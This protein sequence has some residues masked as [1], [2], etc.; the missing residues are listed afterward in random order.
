[1]LSAANSTRSRCASS[2]PPSMAVTI[3]PATATVTGAEAEQIGGRP[4]AGRRLR[5]RPKPWRAAKATFDRGDD[6]AG[7]A[8][9][10]G[11]ERQALLTRR[12]AARACGDRRR[13]HRRRTRR[14]GEA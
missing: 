8:G 4:V 10:G 7:V 9:L 3:A 13:L 2:R 11:D 12:A 5:P 14:A 6:G 1:M